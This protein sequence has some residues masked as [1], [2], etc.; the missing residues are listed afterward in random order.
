MLS[1]N[2][3]Q[4]DV[5]NAF[6]KMAACALAAGTR[7]KEYLEEAKRWNP[8]ELKTFGQALGALIEEMEDEHFTDVLG[9]VHMD[10]LG[11]RGQSHG[12]EFHTP[13]SVC[14]LMA[15]VTIGDRIQDFDRLVQENGH[16][17]VSEPACGAGAMFLALAKALTQAGRADL[18]ARLRVV[19]IDINRAACDMCFINTTLW[20]IPATIVHGNTLSLQTWGQWDNVHRLMP[21]LR[22]LKCDPTTRPPAKLA[23]QIE[24]CLGPTT[25]H[26]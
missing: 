18:I 24:F 10:N 14:D 13:S 8:D 5:F 25:T 22:I 2:R 12:G 9:D 11:H 15:Q 7:E 1:S 20:G 26:Q 21:D 17:K 3:S 16:V 6:L 23:A 4:R 19:G